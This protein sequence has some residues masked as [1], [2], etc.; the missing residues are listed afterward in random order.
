MNKFNIIV[1]IC[2][3]G[4]I[5]GSVVMVVVV[6]KGAQEGSVALE[7][8]YSERTKRTNEIIKICEKRGGIPVMDILGVNL[9]DCLGIEK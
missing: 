3:L 1:V 8:A 2:F 5:I 9:K 4:I 7:E 6:M